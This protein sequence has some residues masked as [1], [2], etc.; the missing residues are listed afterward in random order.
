MPLSAIV[1]SKPSC[2]PCLWVKRTLE[3]HGVPFT[4]LDVTEDAAAEQTVRDLYASHRPGQMP[5]T[6]V[7]L[8]STQEGVLTVFGADIRGHLRAAVASAAA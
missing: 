4:E 7:T 2:A 8:L 1:Y 3:Q 5:A 6:P